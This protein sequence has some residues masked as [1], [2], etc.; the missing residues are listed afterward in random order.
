MLANASGK[1][2]VIDDDV[3]LLQSVKRMLERQGYQVGIHDGSPGCSS[4]VIRFEADL[5]LVDV[6]MPFL[7]GDYFVSLFDKQPGE[8][9]PTILLYSALD[10]LLLEKRAKECGADGYIMKSD[11][12]LDFARKLAAHMRER[13]SA[14][15]PAKTGMTP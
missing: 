11:S 6:K 3:L 8:L 10:E 5:V 2:F 4:Q 12:S 13:L 14:R 1:V 7:S 9:R 15:A